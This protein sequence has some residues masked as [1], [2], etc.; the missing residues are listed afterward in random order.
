LAQAFTADGRF[1]AAQTLSG[2]VVL[3]AAPTGREVAR[4]SDPQGRSQVWL[5]FSHDAR[6][7]AAIP[8]GSKAVSVWNIGE[9][10]DRLEKLGAGGERI[11]SRD[12]AHESLDKLTIRV[13]GEEPAQLLVKSLD[14]ITEQLRQNPTDQALHVRR[15]RILNELN[16]P[17]EA[18]RELTVAIDIA[19]DASLYALR[20]Q[21]HAAANTY[22]EAIGDLDKSLSIVKSGDSRESYFCGQLAWYCLTGPIETRQPERALALA[23]RALDGEPGR[24]E[25]LNTLGVAHC[26]RSEWK[27]AVDVLQRSLSSGSSAPAHDW[28]FLALAWHNLG[29]AR[30]AADFFDQAVYWHDM[31]E[32][33]LDFMLQRE[34]REIRREIEEQLSPAQN[35]GPEAVPSSGGGP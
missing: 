24:V 23:R 7:L 21:A 15:G 13:R 19:P 16:R 14:E 27:Q 10:E 8:Y 31:H 30:L 28:Y 17:E 6:F 32:P 26:R 5:A 2:A 34:L 35:A 18:V 22:V 33:R 29:N 12:R 11:S 25:Y 4:L 1:I 20:A 9:V 3:Y